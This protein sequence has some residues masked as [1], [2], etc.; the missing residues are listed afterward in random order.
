M[1]VLFRR[2]IQSAVA[3]TFLTTMLRVGANVFVLPLI[4]RKLPP[5]H[6][7]L[8]YVFLTIGGIAL[9]ADAKSHFFIGVD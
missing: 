2:T 9:M 4:L 8:W 6:L 1:K 3:W 5:E 7:G